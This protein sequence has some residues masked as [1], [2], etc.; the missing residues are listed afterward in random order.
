MKILKLM[1]LGGL[2]GQ[3]LGWL[4]FEYLDDSYILIL[5]GL[6]ALTT[7]IKYFKDIFYKRL[8]CQEN[9]KNIRTLLY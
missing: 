5:I 8:F 1:V 6:L 2:I 3:I 7:S 9:K 4:C